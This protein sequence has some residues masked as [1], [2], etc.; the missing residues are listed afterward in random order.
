MG[1]NACPKG[2]AHVPDIVVHVDF[3]ERALA[4]NTLKIPRQIVKL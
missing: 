2:C 3:Q 4:D 1:A